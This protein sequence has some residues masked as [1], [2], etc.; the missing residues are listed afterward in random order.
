MYCRMVIGEAVSP[1]QIQALR[2]MFLEEIRSEIG[3][4]D[5]NVGATFMV[6]EGGNMVVLITHWSNRET[7]L[8]YHASR[9]YRQFVAKTQHLL[10]GSFVVKL[11]R[12]E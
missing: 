7:C 9:G 3:K 11:F 2:S 12:M 10:I 5:G 8:K 4:E 6:E 1:D